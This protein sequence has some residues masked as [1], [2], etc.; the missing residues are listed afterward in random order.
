MMTRLTWTPNVSVERRTLALLGHFDLI[1]KGETDTLPPWEGSLPRH[2][3]QPQN[4]LV[5]R[6]VPQL[7]ETHPDLSPALTQLLHRMIKDRNQRLSSMRQIAA[8]LEGIQ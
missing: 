8:E 7:D 2:W 3:Y 1:Q 6:P 5:P 4:F